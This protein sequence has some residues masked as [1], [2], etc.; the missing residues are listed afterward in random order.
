MTFSKLTRGSGGS[1]GSDERGQSEVI[2]TILLVAIAIVVAAGVGQ[3]VFGLDIVAFGE[4][5]VGPQASFDVTEGDGE[6][7][8]EH[9]GG[10]ALDMEEITI[11][12]GGSDVENHG[13]DEEWTSGEEVTVEDLD[14][15]ETVR[16][17]W[18]SSETDDSN[19]IFEHEFEG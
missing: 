8:I 1:G 14:P 6:M 3:F 4:Q 10:D 17:I 15:G 19:V 16:I 7:T 5:T 2:G 9:Q 18:R 12:A 11:T 13:L